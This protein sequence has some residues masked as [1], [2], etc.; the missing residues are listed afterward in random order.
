MAIGLVLALVLTAG[1]VVRSRPRVLDVAAVPVSSPAAT[2]PAG[3]PATSGIASARATPAVAAPTPTSPELVVQVIGKVRRPGV[4]RLPPGARVVDA[5]AA[6]G[7][8]AKGARLGTLNL[9]R[10][11]VDGEQI[12]VGTN[13]GQPSSST[14]YGGAAPPVGAPGVTTPPAAGGPAAVSL[15]AADLTALETLPGVGPVLAQRILDFRIE[16]GRFASVDELREVKGIGDKTF[17]E[18]APHVSL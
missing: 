14:G 12:A 4:V 10:P 7:G 11:V 3:S 6:A 16:N 17:A 5:V 18:I 8:V 9:A 1:V 2:G 13:S 15:N